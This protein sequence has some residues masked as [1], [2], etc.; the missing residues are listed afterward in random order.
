M[1]I[2]H[3][4]LKNMIHKLSKLGA[5]KLKPVLVDLHKLRDLV[6][7]DVVKK[8][9]SDAK[10]KDIEDKI[11]NI[12][13]LATNTTLNSNIIEVKNEILSITNL[14]T[15][16]ALNATI[17]EVKTEIHD[18]TNLTTTTAITTVENQIYK[19]ID[20]V[21]KSDHD[22]EVKDNKYFSASDYDKST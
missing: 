22:A 1:L 11:T 16:T 21:K 12:T 6:K 5:D 3:I 17:N 13:N 14:A 20:L 15:T 7:N 9:V 19:V 4:L 10:I 2:H 18:I 8:D